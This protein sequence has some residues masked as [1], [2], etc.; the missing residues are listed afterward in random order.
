MRR[1]AALTGA[2]IAAL[3]IVGCGSTAHRSK[4]TELCPPG[5]SF[6]G[7]ASGAVPHPNHALQNLKPSGVTKP[8]AGCLFP[9]VSSYQGHPD[10]AAASSS[11]CAAVAKAG[12]SNFEDPDFA[13]NVASLRALHIPWAG[14][15]FVRGCSEGPSFVSVLNSVGFRG[16]R[17]ALRPVE[18]MEVP[19]AF[20]CAVPIARAIHAAFGVWPIIYTAPGTWP[21]GASGGLEAWEADYGP[22]LA[23]LPFAA[24]VLA[25]QRYSPPYTYRS[26][27]GLG[28]GDVSIDLRGFS[29]AL[30]FP[31]PTV[32]P[33]A[34]YP[35]KP[36]EL[37]A[38]KISERLT[39][40][41]WWSHGCKNPVRRH[42]CVIDR[43]NLQWLAGRLVTISGG[44]WGSA[45]SGELKWGPR[46]YRIERILNG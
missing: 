33:F 21:G 7:C 42:V 18:D 27:P 3:L 13:Y 29:K 41:S 17:D 31:A 40:E 8:V 4:L 1:I 12:E 9:D 19:S 37:Y 32:S 44:H 11:I 34:I 39:V 28:Y 35:L 20:G 26:I 25:W 24:V 43:R 5:R 45:R 2:L 36:V 16:D 38:H 30:A 23:A 14:Y 6:M 22:S 15:W 46:H 10:W